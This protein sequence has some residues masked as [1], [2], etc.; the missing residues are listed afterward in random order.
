MV[1]TLI[2]I[3][4]DL[5]PVT[6][7]VAVGGLL[8]YLLIYTLGLIRDLDNPFEYKDGR[9]GVADVSLDV[10]IRHE[11]RLKLDAAR[12][13]GRGGADARPV[14][15][16]ADRSVGGQSVVSSGARKVVAMRFQQTLDVAAPPERVFAA[17]ADVTRWP[18]W[19]DSVSSVELIDPGP[20]AVG[21]RARVRQPKLPAAVWVV[22]E[23][24]P[25]RAFTWVAQ[26]PGLRSTGTH[27]VEPLPDG[28]S[29]RHGHPRPE[30]PARRCGRPAD[31]GSDR[32]LPGDGAARTPAALRTAGLSPGARCLGQR[33]IVGP[34][35]PYH[36]P[37]TAVVG[38]DHAESIDDVLERMATIDATLPHD[39]GVAYFNR[40]YWQV[41]RLVAPRWTSAF[42]AG[43]F[44]ERLDVHFA[45]LYFAAYA[46][47]LAGTPI[48]PAWA[49]L[50]EGRAREHPPD[51]VRAGRDERPHLPRPAH[52]R[53]RHLPRAS[54]ARWSAA[55]PAQR[56]H[57]HQRRARRRAGAD[58]GLV[59][60][61]GHR[62]RRPAR[63]QGRRRVRHVRHPRRTSCGL[64]TSE[65]LWGLS[66]N[67]RLD[68]M[69]RAGL[70]RS[71][72]LTSRGI[73][74]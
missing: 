21:S 3:F 56:L 26:G 49:P 32:E 9:P 63:R 71:V 66:G 7:N 16:G 27:A 38:W 45:N 17:Y 42:E 58:Q 48:S 59:H 41:T 67:Q 53:R 72:E 22:T 73:L 23:M 6:P 14:P 10:L 34:S 8:A 40:M 35:R 65:V 15:R 74:L 64:E 20:L 50:F 68:R 51:P 36:L 31:Q 43:E 61:R 11:E 33:P 18:E 5:G 24:F 2:I 25:D 29:L 57:A 1:L 12:G 60:Q 4:T 28:G 47:D 69:F 30:R 13:P 54:R 37:M 46:A 62:D 44:L 39:D 70:R 19:T 52:R 55:P